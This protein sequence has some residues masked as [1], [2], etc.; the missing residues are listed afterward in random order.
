MANTITPPQKT[1]SDIAIGYIGKTETP[2]NSGFV[3][4]VFQKKMEEVGWVKSYAWCCYFSE[5]CVKEWAILIGRKDIVALLPKLFSGSATATY[6]N[7]E[8]YA[9][10]NPNGP[11]RVSKTP[12]PNSVAIYRHGIGWQGHAAVTINS[13]KAADKNTYTKNV[14]GNTN[15]KGGREGYIVAR[16]TRNHNAP[17]T[18][19]G[20]NIVGYI[21]FV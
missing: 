4:K 17:F 18:N 21:Y 19:K 10:Q 16:K 1:L 20:L 9:Q 13:A 6:K 8:L 5:L 7:C 15:D 14:E 12:V 3:D 2:N 11:I